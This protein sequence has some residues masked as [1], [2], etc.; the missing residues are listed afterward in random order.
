M[1]RNVFFSFHYQRDIS[2]VNVVRN[3]GAFK[4]SLQ[5]TGYID[6]SLWEKSKLQGDA[7]LKRL[8]DDGL[9][10]STVT[11]VLVG[12]ETAGRRW[13]DYEI[14]ESYK[15]GNGII[16]IYI[17]QI[18]TMDE[19]IDARGDNPLTKWTIQKGGKTVSL[20]DLYPA[21]DWV[22]DDGYK[23]FATWV[24]NAAKAADK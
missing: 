23:N 5:E 21:Y 10:G 22:T 7:A 17:H 16:A 12:A 4:S 9:K 2:R 13:V 8:I 15:R 3:H 11:A 20:A 1:A 14:E 19:K 6:H 18:R 24:E